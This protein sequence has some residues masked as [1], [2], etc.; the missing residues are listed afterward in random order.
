[1][2]FACDG[3][4]GILITGNV[5]TTKRIKNHF[6]EAVNAI[7][8]KNRRKAEKA[9]DKMHPTV[10]HVIKKVNNFG[11]T[12]RNAHDSVIKGLNRNSLNEEFCFTIGDHLYAQ[13]TFYTHHGIYVG[14]GK[15]IHYLKEKVSETSLRD[16]ACG[17]KIFIKT[18]IESPTHFSRKEA[19]ARA[20][21]RLGENEYNLA[22]NN[23]DSF[24]RW[25][26]NGV[27]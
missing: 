14:N 22:I 13:R 8:E 2:K 10:G 27:D 24:V 4:N 21:K 7:K 5:K 1:M 25:C 12:A 26:R 17:A 19:V 9:F 6:K 18:E 16:F 11:D 15:V 3:L 20:K 23:C